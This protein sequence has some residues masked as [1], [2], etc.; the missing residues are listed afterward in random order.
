MVQIDTVSLSETALDLLLCSTKLENLNRHELRLLR[1]IREAH[2]DLIGVRLQKKAVEKAISVL[3]N[4]I[5][6]LDD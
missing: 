5:K 6:V 2:Q 3:S 1:R 4:N